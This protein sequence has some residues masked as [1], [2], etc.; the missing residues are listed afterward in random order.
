M[1]GGIAE[2]GLLISFLG[3]AWSGAD[4][5][6]PFGSGVIFGLPVRRYV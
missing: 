2:I 3:V 5:D 1:I 6:S 4:S